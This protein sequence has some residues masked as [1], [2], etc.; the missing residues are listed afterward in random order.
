MSNQKCRVGIVGYGQIGT[1]V[2]DQISKHPE[3]GIEIAF[4]HDNLTDRLA[5]LPKDVALYDIHEFASR[6]PDVVCELAHRDVSKQYGAMF[7][8]K[9]DYFA[10]SVTAFSDSELEKTLRE[11]ALANSRRLLV[12]HGA[13]MGLDAIIEA[14]EVL[15]EVHFTMTKN[16]INIDFKVSGIDPSTIKTRTVVYDGPTRGVCSKFPRNVNTHAAVALAGIGFDR[17]HSMLIADPSM[18]T[19]LLEIAA[20]G[21][22]IDLYMRRADSIK[23]VSGLATLQ[24]V[25]RSIA[26]LG[27]G[28]PGLQ[29]C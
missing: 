3:W 27:Q 28:G 23:G 7:L 20:K 11:A 16:P 5:T 18:D 26:N 21:N 19:A 14:R 10:L 13:V 29:F 9:A 8:E 1:Y 24:S 2:Y 15:E 6:K 22:G 25:V 4:I 12:P 17:T